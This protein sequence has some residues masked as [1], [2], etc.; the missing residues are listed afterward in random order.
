MTPKF[1]K[2]FQPTDLDRPPRDDGGMANG[3]SLRDWFAAQAL[4]APWAQGV[5][6]HEAA[7][8]AEGIKELA[9]N[10]YALADAMLKERRTP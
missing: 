5:S 7:E 10:C 6:L 9:A 8:T 3:M 2:P 4:S 1:R